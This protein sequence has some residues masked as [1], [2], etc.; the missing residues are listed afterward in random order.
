M[1]FYQATFSAIMIILRKRH[2]VK[3]FFHFFKKSQNIYNVRTK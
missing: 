1:L 2:L 3:G